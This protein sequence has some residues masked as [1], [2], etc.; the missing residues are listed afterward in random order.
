MRLLPYT[1]QPE[2]S[3]IEVVGVSCLH[4]GAIT[5]MEKK[6]MAHRKYILADPDRKALDLGDHCENSLR[7]SPGE[8]V[9]Q[10]TCS[11]DQQFDWV[12]EYYRPMGD[13]LLGITSGNHE[14]RTGKDSSIPADKWLTAVLGCPWIHWEAIL[15]ITVGD[16][17]HGQNYTIY[18]RHAVSN[19]AKPHVILGAMVNQSR[20]IQDCDV[21]AFAHN[22]MYLTTSIPMQVPDP[23]HHKVKIKE[24]H[25]V[26]GDSFMARDTS[27]A[28][29][30]NFPLSSMGQFRLRL[31]KDEHLVEVGRLVY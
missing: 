7:S 29:Q 15:S 24:Q 23:R 11:P 6:A 21:Y 19:S 26:M 4:Y 12:A 31:Y 14:D 5:F 9:F 13:K 30:R 25:F 2:G 3:F 8:A 27:Y 18:T 10:Q 22:H 17:K 28:E 1:F 16:S 20:P